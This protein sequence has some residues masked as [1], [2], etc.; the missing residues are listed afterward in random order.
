M[1]GFFNLT[2]LLILLCAY[3]DY[4]LYMYILMSDL[5]AH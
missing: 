1:Y 5:K 4:C 2:V 3:F